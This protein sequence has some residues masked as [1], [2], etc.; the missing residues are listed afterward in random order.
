MDALIFFSSLAGL[1]FIIWLLSLISMAVGNSMAHDTAEAEEEGK[2]AAELKNGLQYRGFVAIGNAIDAYRKSRESQGRQQD[3]RENVTV[4]LVGV[5]ALFAVVAAVVAIVSAF[6]FQGQ[7]KEARLD[8]RPWISAETFTMIAPLQIADDGGATRF[9]IQIKN[10]G[11]LP[12]VRIGVDAIL[13]IRNVENILE[14]QK[15]YCDAIRK[16]LE[17][18]RNTPS[19]IVPE[20]TLF[21]ERDRPVE[22]WAGFRPED[23][24]RYRD[25]LERIPGPAALP[26]MVGCVHYEFPSEEGYHFTGFILD[27]NRRTPA[28]YVPRGPVTAQIPGAV[29]FPGTTNPSDISLQLS[30]VGTGTID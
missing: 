11:K 30:F 22:I 29:L 2:T 19:I 6:I 23:F 24:R 25:W 14:K 3:K 16:N 12:A 17:N 15:W 1:V 10:V 7:L 18:E 28:P 13:L 26:T 27:L 20:I 4:I 21:P 5:T 9:L 8:S